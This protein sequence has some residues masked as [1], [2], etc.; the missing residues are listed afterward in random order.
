MHILVAFL[1]GAEALGGSWLVDLR[2]TPASKPAPQAMS[3]TIAADGKVTGTFY[4]AAIADGRASV[5]NGR[6][7]AAFTTSDNSGPYQHSAC[8]L[9]NAVEGLSWSTG[10]NFLLAWKAER[11]GAPTR[12]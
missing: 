4:G 12:P 11:G 1:A 2:P 9:G 5:S 7:C 8:L 6:T 10:R 3:L